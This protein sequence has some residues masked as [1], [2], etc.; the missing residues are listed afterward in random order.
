VTQPPVDVVANFVLLHVGRP[1]RAAAEFARVLRPGGKVALSVWDVPDRARF[2]GV[3]VD[4][5]AA[6]GAAPPPGIPVGPP[7]FRFA[8][9]GELAGLLHGRALE[10][11]E[12]ETISFTHPD[13]SADALWAG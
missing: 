1:E 12:V 3:L 13:P 9:D 4:A 10:D 11:V 2:I 6:A 7:I 8:D 5:I